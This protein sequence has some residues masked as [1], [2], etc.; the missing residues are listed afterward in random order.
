MGEKI[1][2]I[3]FIKIV[4]EKAADN[5]MVI[6]DDISKIKKLKEKVI[7]LSKK[8]PL[9]AKEKQVFQGLV[10]YP[11]D[12]DGQLSSKLKIKRSTITAIRNKLK[13]QEFYNTYV[14]PNFQSINCEL[15][16]V[17]YGKF[18]S[19]IKGESDK[20]IKELENS[21]EQIYTA[22]TNTD[23]VSICISKNLAN[24][25]KH[26]DNLMSKHKKSVS[27]IRVVYFPFEMNEF[28]KLFEFSPLVSNILK[29]RSKEKKI[30]QVN[31]GDRTLN[32]KEKII[33]YAL[34]KYSELNDTEIA[35][36]VSLSRP[37]ISQTKQKLINEGFIKIVNVPSYHKIGS[38]LL[39]LDHTLFDPKIADKIK[40]AMHVSSNSFF[41]VSGNTE[42]C[43]LSLYKDYS[44]YKQVHKEMKELLKDV[45]TRI[46]TKND[47]ILPISHIQFQKLDFAPIV[48]RVLDLKVNF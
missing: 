21:P 18:S 7:A 31:M 40:N 19:H 37:N 5:V 13:K 6:M 20:F 9:S 35:K 36:K 44:E 17:I 45:E 42:S 12:N 28:V 14:I 1:L 38:E 23:I 46:E 15:L 34:V 29:L 3:K 30:R 10:E 11:L 4:K 2:N 43:N 26:L 8:I 48:K 24:I 25:K 41:T 47:I 39:V 33:L 16:T 22:I 27:D 32:S